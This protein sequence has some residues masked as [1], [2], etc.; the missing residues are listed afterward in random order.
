MFAIVTGVVG[1]VL[2]RDFNGFRQSLLVEL[3]WSDANGLFHKLRT[4]P[5]SQEHTEE[6]GVFCWHFERLMN[7]AL[8]VEISEVGS[9][10]VPII[11]ATLEENPTVV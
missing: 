1:R 11:S 8:L 10:I 6:L 5:A 4:A 2:L 3:S 9:R 7:F